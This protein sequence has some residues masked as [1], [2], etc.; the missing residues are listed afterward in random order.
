MKSVFKHEKKI[1]S[2]NKNSERSSQVLKLKHSNIYEFNDSDLEGI[3]T[4]LF[5]QDTDMYT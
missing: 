2:I 1:S 4:I 3:T 5:S